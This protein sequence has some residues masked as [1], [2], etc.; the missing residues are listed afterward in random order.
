M[1]YY[2]LTIK[3]TRLSPLR[4]DYEE[5]FKYLEEAWDYHIGCVNF[6]TTKGLHVHCLLRSS[7]PLL[8]KDP[9]LYR[10]QH[11]WNILCVPIFYEKG[12]IAYSTKDQVKDELGAPAPESSLIHIDHVLPDQGNEFRYPRLDIRNY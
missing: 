5:Y 9:S 11:G 1:H 8:K 10:D 12:W 4:S 7:V 3:K 2:A 6:E